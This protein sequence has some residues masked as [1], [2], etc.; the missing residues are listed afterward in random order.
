[1]K[2]SLGSPTGVASLMGGWPL[3]V[4]HNRATDLVVPALLAP[5]NNDPEKT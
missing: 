3:A 5:V 2:M 4:N 1:M